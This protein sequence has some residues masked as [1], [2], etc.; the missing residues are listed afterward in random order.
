[1]EEVDKSRND[2]FKSRNNNFEN[3]KMDGLKNVI[4]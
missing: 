3:N 2:I 1:M 4:H